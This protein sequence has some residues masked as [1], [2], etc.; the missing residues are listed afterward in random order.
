MRRLEIDLENKLNEILITYTNAVS[1]EI[2][3]TA[4]EVG[5]MAVRQLKQNS[6]KD[7]PEYYKGWSVK[8]TTEGVKVHNATYPGLTHILEKGYVLKTGGR[9]RAQPHIKP[10]EMMVQSNFMRIL[11]YKIEGI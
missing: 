6:P 10:V 7:R 2:K 9:Y 3:E 4:K 11:K 8:Q 1:D 5:D